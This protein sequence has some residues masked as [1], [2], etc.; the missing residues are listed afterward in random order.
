EVTLSATATIASRDIKLAFGIA[1]CQRVLTFFVTLGSTVVLARLLN[2]EQFG[3]VA[4]ATTVLNF[5][6]VFRDFGLTSATIQR[7][8]LSQRERDYL[9]WMNALIVVIISL[10]AV[11]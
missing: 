4:M 7:Q 1:Y 2:P 10:V 9:F 5:L 11:F 3:Y 8:N 6:A